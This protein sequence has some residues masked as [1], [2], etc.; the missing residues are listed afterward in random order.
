MERC[1][2]VFTYGLD[3]PYIHLSLARTLAQHGVW[4][5]TPYAT[6][7]CVSSIAWPLLLAAIFR[8]A[9]PQEL[10][11]LLLNF[12]A[13]LVL[14]AFVDALLRRR[15][16]TGGA[17]LMV[18][19][20]V[21]ILTPLPALVFGGME[22]ILHALALLWL[23]VAAARTLADDTDRPG[24][25]WRLALAALLA[26]SVRYESMA[27]VAVVVVLALLRGRW[28]TGLVVALLPA[29]L[30]ALRA[31]LAIDAGWWWLPAS[32]LMKGTAAEFSAAQLTELSWR[33]A[34][35][36]AM[37]PLVIIM[38]GAAA[39]GLHLH[40][41]EGNTRWRE[42]PLLLVML[43]CCLLAQFLFSRTGSLYRYEAYLYALGLPI[44]ALG[45]RIRGQEVLGFMLV[46]L[47]LPWQ[48]RGVAGLQTVEYACGNIRQQQR[49]MGEFLRDHFTGATVVAND[50]GMI[51]WL[52]DIHLVDLAGLASR[53]VAAAAMRGEWTCATFARVAQ[54]ADIALVYDSWYIMAGGLPPSWR[55]QLV[56]QMHD[57]V[58]CGSEYV[59]FYAVAPAAE[60]RLRTA[61]AGFDPPNA[62]LLERAVPLDTFSAVSYGTD[63]RGGA[64]PVHGGEE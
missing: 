23:L 53:E 5:V 44:I 13:A 29:A 16:M 48:D 42:T 27:A 62:E 35:R 26:V 61:L 57:N 60:A 58:V 30:L 55:R 7:D 9:G 39:L 12:L 21:I 17:R 32:V 56:W 38:G 1:S 25:R 54:H 20:G 47:L 22:H 24:A 45:L 2:G 52:A 28:R 64:I 10:A 51:T 8:V 34:T 19:L 6:A 33:F 15:L 41:R 18:M 11:P 31:A 43:M 4:G 37:M 3:D 59:S 36:V 14:L 40:R 63:Y 50:I 49:V 46:C